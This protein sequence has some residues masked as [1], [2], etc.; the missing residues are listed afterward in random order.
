MQPVMIAGDNATVAKPTA[1]NNPVATKPGPT[2]A[3][4]SETRT[5]LVP[6][7]PAP[8]KPKLNSKDAK[9]LTGSAT[10]KTTTKNTKSHA[11]TIR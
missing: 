10:N 9:K 2:Q 3:A 5:A 11:A 6:K 7:S 8:A 1:A 4:H